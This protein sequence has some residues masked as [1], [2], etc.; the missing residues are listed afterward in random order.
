[1]LQEDP[2]FWAGNNERKVCLDLK[3]RRM[4]LSY[5]LTKISREFAGTRGDEISFKDTAGIMEGEHGLR[6]N[7]VKEVI[8][9]LLFYH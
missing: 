5:N 6:F 1:M 2:V 8:K 9:F 3:I 7:P 4:N